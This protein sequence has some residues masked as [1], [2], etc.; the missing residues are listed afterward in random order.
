[1]AVSVWI[2]EFPIPGI[3]AWQAH[4]ELGLSSHLHHDDLHMCMWWLLEEPG[5]T[6]QAPTLVQSVAQPVAKCEEASPYL[7]RSNQKTKGSSKIELRVMVN[8]T[9]TQFDSSH[10][11]TTTGIR[12]MLNLMC[13]WTLII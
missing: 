6:Q 10:P 12:F 13:R 5:V 1:M 3:K 9:D 7:L 11:D 4:S 8:I 2:R